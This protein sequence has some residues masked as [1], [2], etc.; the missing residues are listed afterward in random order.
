ME[1]GMEVSRCAMGEH[2]IG[3]DSF[4]VTTVPLHKEIGMFQDTQALF[5]SFGLGQH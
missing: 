5:I 4:N 1:E 2:T 3:F